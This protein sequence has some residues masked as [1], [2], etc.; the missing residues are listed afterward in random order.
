MNHFIEALEKSIKDRNWYSVLFISLTLPDICGKVNQ[1]YYEG[2]TK[3][4]SAAFRTK[5][6][7]EVYLDPIVNPMIRGEK[8]VFLSAVD[9]YKLRCALLH[10]GR[11]VISEHDSV[12][13][14]SRFRF[15]QPISGDSIIH[16]NKI[17]NT[18][19]LQVDQFGLE[20]LSAVKT[21]MKAIEKDKEKTSKINSMLEVE[22]LD[23][24]KGF[25]I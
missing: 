12:D 24:T 4:T 5:K 23:F 7:F 11:D 20:V 25:S 21:W 14:L 13:I 19:Q 16:M 6:W 10:E 1:P 15:V 9:F 3:D 8:R 22:M 18:L 17:D 2:T